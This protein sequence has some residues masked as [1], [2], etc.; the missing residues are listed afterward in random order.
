MCG[1]IG[2]VARRDVVPFLLEGLRRVEY[3]GYDSAGLAVMRD[4][5]ER[6]RTVGKV[7]ELEALV[8]RARPQPHGSTGIAHTRWATHGEP[9]ET[10]AHP[11]MC[12][13][14][15][16]VVHNGI[17]ENHADIRAALVASGYRFDSETDT[18]VIGH[19]IH[20]DLARGDDLLEAVR[21]TVLILEGS[22]AFGAV[23]TG[24]PHRLVAAVRGSPLIV[25][26]GAGE[27]FIA[28]D[29]AALIGVTRQYM[30]LEDGDIADLTAE[31]VRVTDRD[32][33]PVRRTVFTN[34][35][36]PTMVDRGK[37]RHFMAKEIHEQPETV[38]GGSRR[39]D[40]RGAGAGGGV[41]S[42]RVGGVRP[43]PGRP[44]HRVRDRLPRRARGP[45]LVRGARRRAVPG[46]AGERVPLP[47]AA[48]ASD[49]PGGGAL[50]V[51]R[52]GRYPRRPARGGAA[53][54]RAVPRHR[55][56]SEQ[57]PRACRGSRADD[58]RPGR[59]SE[60]L[61]PR[62]SPPSSWPCSCSSWRSAGAGN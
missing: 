39:P 25:G 22:Y 27:H 53:G 13:A 29:V 3:R 8:E 11:L 58:Q 34:T 19:R 4:R 16:A 31:A 48:W 62:R 18:E 57:L 61:R 17:I 38:G 41:R 12:R 32:G 24:D 33:R 5:I 40:L 51:R 10:N 35:M 21:S 6:V 14:E 50:P 23:A 9:N 47:R 52:D 37:W 7:A 43:G 56:R 45:A 54:V 30:V 15:V 1:I 44:D 60:S 49:H 28:S 20:H 59:R 42:E 55:E 36:S 2:A 46:G 26:V